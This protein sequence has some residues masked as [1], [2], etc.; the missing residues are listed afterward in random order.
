MCVHLGAARFSDH[1]P[2]RRTTLK[3]RIASSVAIAAALAL[4]ATGCTL[5]APQATLIRYAPSDGVDVNVGSVDVRNIMLIADE[6]GENFNVVF[7]AANRSGDEQDLTITFTGTESQSASAEFTIP[8]GNTLFGDPEGDETP[9]LVTLENLRVGSTV[10]AYFQLPGEPEVPYNIPVLDGTLKEYRDYVLPADFSK[11]ADTSKSGDT[12]TADDE[13]ADQSKI[14]DD[15]TDQE[16][17]E[18]AE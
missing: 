6:S 1:P 7:G 5:I 9:V 2:T 15:V 17:T 8:T 14:G 13:A 18:A 12:T 10:D 3:I 16:A 4:G 11:S